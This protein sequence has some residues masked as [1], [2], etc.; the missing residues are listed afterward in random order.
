MATYRYGIND[1]NVVQITSGDV[2]ELLVWAFDSTTPTTPETGLAFGSVTVTYCKSNGTAFSAWPASP[3][4]GTGNWAEIGNGCYRLIFTGSVAA[5]LAL[6]DTT[7]PMLFHL[8]A[9][10]AIFPEVERTIVASGVATAA[11]QTAENTTLSTVNTNT[12]AILA[13]TGTDGV[14][15]AANQI[16]GTLTNVGNIATALGARTPDSGNAAGTYDWSMAL[17]SQRYD[18]QETATGSGTSTFTMRKEDGST[19]WSTFVLRTATS[20]SY[21]VGSGD[22]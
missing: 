7:G 6:L 15:L 4:W 17:M 16:V 19:T 2:L 12:V 20:A 9:S 14:V 3:G 11:N 21:V 18:V 1:K 10:G 8:A 22:S 5:E 13:D